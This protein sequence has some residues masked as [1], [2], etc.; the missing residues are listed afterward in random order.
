[1]NIQL[2]KNKYASYIDLINFIFSYRD[3]AILVL[4]AGFH[5]TIFE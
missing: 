1:M 4:I 5:C 3:I 2:P